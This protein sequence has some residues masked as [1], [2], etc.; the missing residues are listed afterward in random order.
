MDMKQQEITEITELRYPFRAVPDG[1]GWSIWFPDLPGCTS[2]SAAWDEIGTRAREAMEIW[3][4]SEIE[5]GHPIPPPSNDGLN[6][7][8]PSGLS[9]HQTD[10][11]TLL[12]AQDVAAKLGVSRRRVSAL[13][14]RR[15]VGRVIGG[16]RLFAT[17]DIEALRPGPPGR[18][19][20]RT[21][22]TSSMP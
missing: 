12:T 3:L 7:M 1:E 20:T 4:E 9:I 11:A 17:T 16:A 19:K 14:V 8:W 21:A 18:P 5:L 13:A 15:G 10:A 2:F 22:A 6:D